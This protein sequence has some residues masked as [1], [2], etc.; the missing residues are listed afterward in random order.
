MELTIHNSGARAGMDPIEQC[1]KGSGSQEVDVER[2]YNEF[3]TSTFV[4][5]LRKIGEPAAAADLNQDLYL[6][7][8][9][10]LKVFEGRCSWRTWVF[11][12]A[13]NVLAEARGQWWKQ[14][15]D[16]SVELDEAE[17]VEDLGLA[18]NPDEEAARVLLR[19]R[20]KRCLR[21]LSEKA[22]S[23]VVGHYFDGITLRDLTERM[24]LDNP[25]GSRAVM[26][27]AL[28]KLRRCLEGGKEQ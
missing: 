2:L 22:R 19:K 16:R 14:F 25:S 24:K 26:L 18:G 8:S 20:L 13:R 5:F 27:A 9:R 10:T 1:G 7:L 3:G 21:L 28:R 23:V 15:G 4:F 11:L 6:R 17:F 12:I